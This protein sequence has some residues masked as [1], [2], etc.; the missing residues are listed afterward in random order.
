MLIAP[1]LPTTCVAA[2][3][4]LL[5][6]ALRFHPKGVFNPNNEPD[7]DFPSMF[8]PKSA[9]RHRL[10]QREKEAQQ[11]QQARLLALGDGGEAGGTVRVVTVVEE[12]KIGD[13]NGAKGIAVARA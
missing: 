6:A 2:V 7:R 3:L 12:G 1:V 5:L 10:L 8:H 11:R 13:A 9:V 4:F